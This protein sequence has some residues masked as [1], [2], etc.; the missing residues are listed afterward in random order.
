M[1]GTRQLRNSLRLPLRIVIADCRNTMN[2]TNLGGWRLLQDEY[3]WPK[4][5]PAITGPHMNKIHGWLS[6]GTWVMIRKYL[7]PAGIVLEL[8]TWMG[9]SAK[10]MLDTESNIRLVCIDT[11]L[12][13][14]EINR[15]HRDMLAT[16]IDHCRHHLWPYRERVVLMQIDQLLGLQKAAECGVGPRL[17]YVDAAHDEESVYQGVL[18]A[19]TTFP[20]AHLVGDDWGASHFGVTEG[21]VRANVELGRN[22]DYNDKAWHLLPLAARRGQC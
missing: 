1:R 20:D 3:P 12:G 14:L 21:V 17:I 19:G 11:W 7:P 15:M 16:I 13:S 22:L 5:R 9:R 2:T 4:N 10:R 6:E 18:A 8:G